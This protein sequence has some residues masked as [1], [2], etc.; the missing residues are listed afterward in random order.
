MADLFQ[1]TSIATKVR[2][3]DDAKNR[4]ID[5][6]GK[7]NAAVAGY[8]GFIS[9]EI[10]ASAAH[11][12]LVIQRFRQ[13]TDLDNWKKSSE[14]RRLL[15]EL[16]A[17]LP[18]GASI[19]DA[20]DDA[21]KRVGVTEVFV[22]QISDDKKE[23]YRNWLEKIHQVEAK[24]PGF[25]GMYVQA[26][27]QGENWITLLQFDSVEN[28]DNWLKSPEREAVLAESKDLIRSLE[29]H[30]VI[31]P[32]A[33]WFSSIVQGKGKAPAL[34]KQTMIILLV[35]FP[36]VMLELRFLSPLLTNL[37]IS[38]STFIGNAISVSLISWPMMPTAIYFLSWWLVPQGQNKRYKTILGTAL[39]VL[40]YLIEIIIFWNFLKK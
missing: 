11:E 13:P 17:I 8:P 24:F 10:L 19:E 12:W 34:W 3:P 38:A 33:G 22:T 29:S 20:E 36:I 27:K 39:V 6:Q 5:W 15:E 28:L 9:I 4:F 18:K 14:Y 7:L 2:I 25:K 26:P 30:R 1:Q 35:L 21:F 23:E 16:K 32:Y 37:D 40:L 31:S